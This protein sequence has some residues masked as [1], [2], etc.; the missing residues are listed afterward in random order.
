MLLDNVPQLWLLPG[1]IVTNSANFFFSFISLPL[2]NPHPRICLLIFKR[3]EKRE[4]RRN[5]NVREKH[6]LVASCRHP[7]WGIKPAT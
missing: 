3:E 1:F 2:F 4:R 6:Q 5:I 7:V